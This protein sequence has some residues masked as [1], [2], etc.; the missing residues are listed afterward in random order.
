M[1]KFGKKQL[2]LFFRFLSE[3]VNVK[4]CSW[5]DLFAWMENPPLW[6]R[7]IRNY[8]KEFCSKENLSFNDDYFYYEFIKQISIYFNSEPFSELEY[9]KYVISKQYENFYGAGGFD[10]QDYFGNMFL[11]YENNLINKF[12]M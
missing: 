7:G 3:E 8:Y 10:S 2:N 12:P 9:N 1:K 4:I 11:W 5:N 6:S